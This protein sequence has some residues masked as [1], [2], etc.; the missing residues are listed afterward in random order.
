MARWLKRGA[1]SEE[2]AETD[3]RVRAAVENIL[4]DIRNDGREPAGRVHD[5]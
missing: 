5:G 3:R 2:L 1:E 4:A